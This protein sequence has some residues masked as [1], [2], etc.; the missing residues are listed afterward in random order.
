MML[1]ARNFLVLAEQTPG[2]VTFKNF[3]ELKRNL[4]DSLSVFEST[5]YTPDNLNEA[6]ENREQL[7]A[8]KKK[9]TDKKKQI[10]KAYT[11]PYEEVK[12]MLDEL[13]DMVKG[14]LNRA[15]EIIKE[16]EREKKKRDIMM[17]AEDRARILGDDAQNVISSPAFFNPRWMNATYKIR[18]IYREIEDIVKRAS[19]DIELIRIK[20]DQ[21][22]PALL[23]RYYEKL[24]LVGLN[25]FLVKLRNEAR[26]TEE[27]PQVVT[28]NSDRLTVTE[29]RK[30][31]VSALET[32]GPDNT[33]TAPVQKIDNNVFETI[34]NSNGTVT[35]TIRITGK[36]ENVDLAV[37]A[38]KGMGITVEDSKESIEV[39]ETQQVPS[40]QNTSNNTENPIK[41]TNHK[42]EDDQVN[43]GPVVKVGSTVRLLEASTGVI[44]SYTIKETDNTDESSLTNAI[45]DKYVGY[46]IL[47]INEND[48]RVEYEIVGID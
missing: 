25:D 28:L 42:H 13:I 20:G 10:E 45:L 1:D 9:L 21:Y 38:I 8:V 36:P 16:C 4:K 35:K 32:I 11:L 46:R 29:E 33:Y 6:I 26:R 41:I 30:E 12:G 2:E 3:E 43:K 39:L 24:T 19:G 5:V 48:E 40:A 18:D 34:H 47:W 44:E 22:T 23:A 37:A 7:K 14:P 17:Y 15:D 27:T 31:L